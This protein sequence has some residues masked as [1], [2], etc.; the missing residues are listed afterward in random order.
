MNKTWVVV[1]DVPRHVF[2]DPVKASIYEQLVANVL[3]LGLTLATIFFSVRSLV[4]R[5]LGKMLG[6]MKDLT[7]G[8]V[9]E[10]VDIPKR[11]DEIGAMAVSIET[12]RQG[13][14][15]KEELEATQLREKQQQEEVVRTLAQQLQQ[16][17]GGRLDVKIHDEM[18]RQYEALRQ[19]FNN[20]VEQL[21]KLITSVNDSADS[22]D[23]GL[24][25]IASATNDLS[26]R[27]EQSALQ[28]EETAASLSELTQN[29]QHVASGARETDALVTSVSQNAT[30]SSAVARETVDAMDS[31]AA[32]SEQI[33]RITGMIDDI[34]F[35][36]NLLALNAGCRSRAGGRSRARVLRGRGGSPQSCP[37]LV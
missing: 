4:R 25:E 19:D 18:P 12:L 10:P 7:E 35:Q 23:T 32:T 22:I 20:T 26:Q 9:H 33:T 30:N 2:V 24:T 8:K 31:I 13:L 21:S 16:L 37:A 15:S 3:L 36:T 5:P 1:L 28:L 6:V 27:T 29:V 17:A 34:A 11:K 14:A